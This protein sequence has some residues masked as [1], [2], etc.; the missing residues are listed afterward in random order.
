MLCVAFLSYLIAFHVVFLPY[1][2]DLGWPEGG[3]KID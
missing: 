3:Y 2:E 1:A